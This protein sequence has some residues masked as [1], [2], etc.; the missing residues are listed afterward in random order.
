M[1]NFLT[2]LTTKSFEAYKY[3]LIGVETI[4][5][6]VLIQKCLCCKV[7]LVKTLTPFLLICKHKFTKNVEPCR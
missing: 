4:S 3:W 1:L 2:T 6:K 7:L 5:L